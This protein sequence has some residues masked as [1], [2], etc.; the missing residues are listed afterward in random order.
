MHD[1]LVDAVEW[2]VQQG[3]ADRERVAIMGGS[4]GG[5]AALVGATFTP[6]VFTA[7]V[8]LVG[9]S[10]LANFMRTQPSFL[11]AAWS[12]TGTGSSATRVT[13]AGSG[14]ARRGPRSAVSTRPRRPCSS[15]REPTTLVSPEPSPDNVVATLR[16]CGVHVDYLVFDDE[17]HGFVNPRTPSRSTARSSG[18]SPSTWWARTFRESS[19]V[20][21]PSG[22]L[23]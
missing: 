13:G 12:T 5:Y 22:S 8:D 2:A 18:S 6:D 19:S 23:S 4:Y 7:A 11:R 20:H 9:I 21:A 14:H 16:S 1:D 10:D 15:R 3:Y 17:G